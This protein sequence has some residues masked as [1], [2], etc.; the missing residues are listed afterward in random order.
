A[1]GGS[2]RDGRGTLQGLLADASPATSTSLSLAAS[3]VT[4]GH[5][6]S[7][8]FSATVTPEAGGIPTG[9]VTV[10]AGSAGLCTITLGGGM[11]SCTL[12]AAKLRPGTYQLTAS[13]SGDTV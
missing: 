8:K 1:A 3:K 13:Y 12:A 5:E 7:A 6:Q 9:K 4:Y 11:G 2:H 10:K